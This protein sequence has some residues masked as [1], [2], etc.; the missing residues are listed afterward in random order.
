MVL[1]DRS[2]RARKRRKKVRYFDVVRPSPAEARRRNARNRRRREARLQ[3][4]YP[5][6]R[7]NER[8]RDV[9]RRER[10]T[11]RRANERMKDRE[12]A[13]LM[14]ARATEVDEGTF[15]IGIG[16]LSVDLGIARFLGWSP[17]KM[18]EAVR[19]MQAS[20]DYLRRMR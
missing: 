16:P 12:A 8:A 10:A 15:S 3:D 11:A 20:A 18:K 17:A 6:K 1:T 9:L 4:R 7:G 5:G 2:L 14:K 13:E 19:R